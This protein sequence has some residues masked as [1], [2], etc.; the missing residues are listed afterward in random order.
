MT[1]V[2]KLPEECTIFNIRLLKD[3]LST[4]LLALNAGDVLQID[5]SD[6]GEWDGATF[7]LLIAFE[8]AARAESTRL[9]LTH[10]PVKFS[11]DIAKLGLAKKLTAGESAL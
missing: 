7:Q 9:Q 1:T 11:S 6:L 10:M 8:N 3:M 4:H 2:I 5:C